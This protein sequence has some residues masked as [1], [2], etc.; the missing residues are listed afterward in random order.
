MYNG[1]IV[2]VYFTY[3][4]YKRDLYGNWC[5]GPYTNRCV[6]GLVLFPYQAN[7]THNLHFELKLKPINFLKNTSE[8]KL[9]CNTKYKKNNFSASSQLITRPVNR[10]MN[11][12]F[13]CSHFYI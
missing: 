4:N 9:T 3:C 2:S 8:K 12:K 13:Q 5:K 6:A 7:K 11:G 10:Y 1:D